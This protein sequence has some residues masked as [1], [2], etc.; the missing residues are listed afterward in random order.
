MFPGTVNGSCALE[1]PHYPAPHSWYASAVLVAGCI[2]KLDG[3][4][5]KPIVRLGGEN[6]S[7]PKAEKFML[8]S[9]EEDAHVHDAAHVSKV[10]P[11]GITVTMGCGR[12]VDGKSILPVL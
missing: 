9:H 1:G 10:S 12:K 8:E 3:K 11:S 7:Q 4:A 6:L 5:P 2:V